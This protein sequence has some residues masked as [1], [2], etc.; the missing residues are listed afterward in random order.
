LTSLRELVNHN[1]PSALVEGVTQLT[2]LQLTTRTDTLAEL[3]AL[4][5]GMSNLQQ[6]EL[7]GS[8]NNIPAESLQLMLST[9][10]QLRK[11][12]LHARIDQRQ[13]EVL[14]RIAPQLTHFACRC[15]ILTD[16]MSQAACSL[17]ELVLHCQSENIGTL[18][19]LPLHCLDRVSF[20][21]HELQ[22]PTARP[23]LRLNSSYDVADPGDMLS[24]LRAALIN[25]ERCPAW[26]QSGP[27]V[28]I[29]VIRDHRHGGGFYQVLEA[30]SA[31]TSKHVQLTLDAR[32]ALLEESTV[33]EL[34]RALGHRLIGLELQNGQ[35]CEDFWAAV[36][37]HLPGL[38]RL[39][40][41][42]T[43]CDGL[44]SNY[45][46]RESLTSFCSHA[47]HPLQLRLGRRMYSKLGVA[48]WK[49]EEQSRGAGEG[50]PRVT[51][52]MIAK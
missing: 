21:D 30:L 1:V 41:C 42:D 47:T 33:Q 22:L 39:T 44:P 8:N 27:T 19:Y 18:A 3:A 37:A 51:V 34:G 24:T 46:I 45:I 4:L 40:L 26:Q 25:L 9:C 6:L 52:E 23:Q 35:L 36:W 29:R 38:Q 7:G 14:L 17:S 32:W 10:T 43:S 11:L 15:L 13:F 28:D 49:L 16:D 20:S 12:T 5:S 50:V 31:V 48:S 2:S